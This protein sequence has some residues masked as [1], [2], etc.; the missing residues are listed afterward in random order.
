M[1]RV[2][3]VAKNQ[4]VIVH[5]EV[6]SARLITK[7]IA[8]QDGRLGDEIM[9]LNPHSNLNYLAKVIGKDQL[10]VQESEPR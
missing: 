2:P 5:A 3:E 1:E 10:V 6:G 4:K 8:L 9:V 7:A